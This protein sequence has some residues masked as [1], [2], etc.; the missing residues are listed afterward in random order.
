[1]IT[2]CAGIC[3]SMRVPVHKARSIKKVVFHQVRSCNTLTEPLNQKSWKSQSTQIPPC[4]TGIKV[5]SIRVA[6][7]INTGKHPASDKIHKQRMKSSGNSLIL[8]T[9]VQ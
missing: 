2:M 5:G 9:F 6:S 8:Q 7:R 4:S 1:M 3:F